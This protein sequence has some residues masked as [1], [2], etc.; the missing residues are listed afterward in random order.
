M[1]KQAAYSQVARQNE[2]NQGE[3]PTRVTN[4]NKLNNKYV[5]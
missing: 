4:F 5:T 2:I 1:D 3:L